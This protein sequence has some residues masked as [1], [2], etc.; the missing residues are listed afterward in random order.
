MCHV[1]SITVLVLLLI[2]REWATIL[3]VPV[4]ALVVER[5]TRGVELKKQVTRL[6][7]EGKRKDNLNQQ[8]MKTLRRK[9]S[10]ELSQ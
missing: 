6:E 3:G 8:L 9:E 10:N 5:L 1:G 7:A 4:S 2:S